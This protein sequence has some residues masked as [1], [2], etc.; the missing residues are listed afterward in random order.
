VIALAAAIAVLP[1]VW[2][3]ATALRDM[4]TAMVNIYQ[5]QY[6]MGLFV[7]EFYSGR[8][9]ALNDVGLVDYLADIDC[10]DLAGLAQLEIGRAIRQRRYDA[11]VIARVTDR[12]GV[13]VGIVYDP[14]LRQAVPGMLPGSWT[15]VGSWQ[16]HHNIV[17]GWDSVS[18]YAAVPEE[19]GPLKSHL[20][21]FSSQ[22]P[23]EVT[24]L[25]SYLSAR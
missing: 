15:R 24:E 1:L 19:T 25:G 23:R 10:L 5:Q 2:R 9:V 11:D 20:R 4:P 13:R 17:C 3:G 8:A 12:A 18:F 7:R 16:I 14:W 21:A 22:L 6:Q